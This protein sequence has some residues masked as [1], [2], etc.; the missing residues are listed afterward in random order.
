MFVSSVSGP[1]IVKQIPMSKIWTR[2]RDQKPTS[3]YLLFNS[4]T[5]RSRC[6]STSIVLKPIVLLLVSLL[7]IGSCYQAQPAVMN[8]SKRAISQHSCSYSTEYILL[9]AFAWL[10]GSVVVVTNG[11]H[12]SV[13][14][15]QFYLSAAMRRRPIFVRQTIWS[16]VH[17]WIDRLFK[18][19]L[20][21][22]SI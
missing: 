21:N 10:S 5:N 15:V 18:V 6:L 8:C 14:F 9:H 1:E 4:F 13:A 19:D 2:L 7:D 11:T 16:G 20:T 17:R 22:S 3:V 12:L